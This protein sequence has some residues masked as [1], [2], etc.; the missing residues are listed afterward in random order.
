[1]A[2]LANEIGD[3]LFAHSRKRNARHAVEIRKFIEVQLDSAIFSDVHHVDGNHHRNFHVG[4]LAR[5]E[6]VAF[7]V[8]RIDNVNN[9]AR[10]AAEQVVNSSAFVFGICEQSVSTRKVHQ[11]N[12][13]VAQ[14]KVTFLLFD[15]HAGPVT[16]MLAGT[17]KRVKESRLTAVRV[18]GNCNRQKFSGSHYTLLNLRTLASSLRSESL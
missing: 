7:Q 6:Q 8:R 17:R 15:R 1:M 12:L 10:F 14:F 4:K 3:A 5:K 11:A 2:H 18:T 13:A 16:H 9:Q